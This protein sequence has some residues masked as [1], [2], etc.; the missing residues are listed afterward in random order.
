MITA[1]ASTAVGQS[2]SMGVLEASSAFLGE[3]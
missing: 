1:Q 3:V 2:Q